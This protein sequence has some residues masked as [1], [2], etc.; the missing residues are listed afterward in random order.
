MAEFRRW[1]DNDPILSRSMRILEKS[2][3][4]DQ[5]QMSIN[6]IKII[7]EHN[8]ESKA[9]AS[10]EDIM[11]AVNDGIIEKGGVKYEK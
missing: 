8:I 5:I 3:D 7:I 9:F 6:L 4:Q 11:Q 2:D 1:Y 10:I